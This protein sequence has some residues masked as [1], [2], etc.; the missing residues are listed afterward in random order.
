MSSQIQSGFCGAE[1]N[2]TRKGMCFSDKYQYVL[3]LRDTQLVHIIKPTIANIKIKKR[4]SIDYCRIVQHNQNLCKIWIW[5]IVRLPLIILCTSYF[6]YLEHLC[7]RTTEKISRLV[8]T[9][10]LVFDQQ[11]KL[12]QVRGP[13]QMSLILYLVLWV[14]KYQ[15]MM[16]C[17]QDSLLAKE[18]M[19]PLHQSLD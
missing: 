4:R 15:R 11:M 10:F 18:I 3:Y 14:N 5:G 7:W 9:S 8:G 1:M 16:I 2:T 13:L 19:S 6:Q 12:L 17:M